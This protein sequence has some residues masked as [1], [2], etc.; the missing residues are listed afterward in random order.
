M[1]DRPYLA[2]LVEHHQAG[3]KD[4]SAAIWALLMFE[5]FLRRVLEGAAGPVREDAA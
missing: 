4:Y 1:F 2:H 3:L 5:A